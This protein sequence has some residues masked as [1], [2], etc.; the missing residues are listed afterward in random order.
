MIIRHPIEWLYGRVPGLKKFL[1]QDPFITVFEKN[2]YIAGGLPRYLLRQRGVEAVKQYCY[3]D[4]GDIDAFFYSHDGFQS[5]MSSFCQERNWRDSVGKN[6]VQTQV[7]LIQNGSKI[8]S[9]LQ[10]I[11]CQF[12]P[13]D[14][15]LDTF[16][17]TNCKIALDGTWV[18]ID[19]E[20]ESL[21]ANN[22]L[23]I[24]KV[25]KSLPSRMAKY[26]MRRGCKVL[27]SR[28]HEALVEWVQLAL[29]GGLGDGYRKDSLVTALANLST[30]IASIPDETLVALVG[31]GMSKL[32]SI[33]EP[34]ESLRGN[35]SRPK[36]QTRFRVL[37]R[38]KVDGAR[39]A[40]NV[41]QEKEFLPGDLVELNF[42]DSPTAS[43]ATLLGRYENELIPRLHY[44]IINGESLSVVILPEKVIR[45]VVRRLSD[46]VLI[47]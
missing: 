4:G 34:Y 15:M 45:R 33:Y 3:D 41:R 38:R 13:P 2:G 16:D 12:L 28:S 30:N 35:S 32:V 22:Q 43:T 37:E 8:S 44:A 42:V 18:W 5:C 10:L 31:H 39:L 23:D 6:A 36:K 25:S 17:F 29:S 27:T 7:L 20:L 24:V 9:R 14:Q 11:K 21:E 47:D 46:A 19:S 26:F 40:L 1:E